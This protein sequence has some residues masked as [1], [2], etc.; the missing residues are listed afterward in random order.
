MGSNR[1]CNSGC[2]VAG[3][4]KSKLATGAGSIPKACKYRQSTTSNTMMEAS[5][6]WQPVHGMLTGSTALSPAICSS[7]CHRRVHRACAVAAPVDEGLHVL[8]PVL[9]GSSTTQ[10]SFLCSFHF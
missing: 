4:L 10:G 7:A 2:F 8:V 5:V 9:C 1:I 3:E 6:C